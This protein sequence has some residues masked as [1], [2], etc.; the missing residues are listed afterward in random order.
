MSRL[1]QV[2]DGNLNPAALRIGAKLGYRVLGD[3]GADR[4]FG[5]FLQAGSD[6]ALRDIMSASD[7]DILK[8]DT[9][10]HFRIGL[11]FSL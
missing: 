4:W 9:T 3:A 5:F 7:G 6:L 8:G 11:E 2:G 1:E 10:Y